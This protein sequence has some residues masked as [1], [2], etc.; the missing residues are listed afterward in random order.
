MSVPLADATG[1]SRWVIERVRAGGDLG[2]EL[3]ALGLVPGTPVRVVRRARGHLLIAVEDARYS[4]GDE[5]ARDVLV[6]RG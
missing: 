3:E 1:P 4:L 6:R 2:H 5:V